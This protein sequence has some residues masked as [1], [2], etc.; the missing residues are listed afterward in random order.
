[1]L[2]LA[3]CGGS[4]T[5]TGGSA[6]AD[7]AG[8]DQVYKVGIV[9]LTEHKALDAATK[10]FQDAL[11]EKL[12][13]NVEFDLNSVEINYLSVEKYPIPVTLPNGQEIKM[14][15]PTGA[16]VNRAKQEAS[17]RAN[18]F[19]RPESD[20][21]E[22]Y[23]TVSIIDVDG[24]DIVEKAD[25]YESLNPQDAIFIDEALKE[26]IHSFGVKLI[27]ETH[28]SSCDNLYSCIIDIASDFFRPSRQISLGITSQKGNLGGPSDKPDVSE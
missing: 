21:T 18:I 10:G 27:R 9:Q 19:K 24:K 2:T 15:F 6:P 7:T 1:M 22:I 12:Q 26:M 8:G 23:T 13:D 16:D 20:F 4:T 25:W 11:K 17:R 28:C 14:R 3:G 5:T